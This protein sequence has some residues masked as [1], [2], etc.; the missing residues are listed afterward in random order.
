MQ[1]LLSTGETG[2]RRLIEELDGVTSDLVGERSVMSTNI[3]ISDGT[4]QL[5]VSDTHYFM[6][7]LALALAFGHDIL[8]LS[9]DREPH[10]FAIFIASLFSSF[11][12]TRISPCKMTM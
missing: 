11:Y 5:Q 9:E 10:G 4:V 6:L 7:A 12:T 8:R 2:N 3:M 1:V